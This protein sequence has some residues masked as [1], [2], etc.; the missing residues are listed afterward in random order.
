MSA[1]PG[2]SSNP[3]EILGLDRT[4]SF[5]DV[6]L[7]YRR[8]ARQ[9]HPDANPD[10][11]Q[12]LARFTALRRAYDRLKIFYQT[13]DAA[14]PADRPPTPTGGL[15]VQTASPATSQ[16]HLRPTPRDTQVAARSASGTLPSDG[17]RIV[18]NI[19][20]HVPEPS[21]PGTGSRRAFRRTG[22]MRSSAE[23]TPRTQADGDR[24]SPQAHPHGAASRAAPLQFGGGNLA[25]RA[26]LICGQPSVVAGDDTQMFYALVGVR[27]SE[28]IVFPRLP[29]NLCLVLD[30]SSSM[31]RGGKVERL[32]DTVRGI[33]DQLDEED[34]LSI[35]TFGDRAE[36]LLPA[37]PLRN[38]AMVQGAIDAMRCRGGT[39]ISRGLTVGLAEL[40]RNASRALSHMILL[41]DGQTY[42][43][44]MIC[45]DRAEEAADMKV[46]VTAYGLGS[47][48]NSALL[49]GIAGATG[50]HSDYI[51]SP[52]GMAAA[53]SAR[54]LALQSTTLCNVSLTAQV[55]S[56][57]TIHRATLVTPVMRPLDF[58]SEQG[59]GVVSLGDISSTTDYR[60]LFEF[61]IG[62][63]KPG[64]VSIASLTLCYDVPGLQRE[65]EKF[66]VP[67]TSLASADHDPSR[68]VDSRITNALRHTTVNR[69]QQQAWSEI[70]SGNLIKGTGYLKRAAEHLE[71]AGHM[72]L[73][74]VAAT[75]AA[76]VE[77]GNTASDENIKRIIYGTRK[78]G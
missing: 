46:G 68:P 60:L 48:W 66:S 76:R 75:E 37:Q 55:A 51:E 77:A 18:P 11:P 50:G 44:E 21:V 25:A 9:Y 30:H 8:L 14:G 27:A 41:T 56:N 45:L 54:V 42:G 2:M 23:L 40:S 5:D 57:S 12:A 32:K 29:L 16:S 62:P 73:A 43:D 34:F 39:E 36:V 59:S 61:V 63:R 24:A 19:R 15:H 7:A 69:L 20:E 74:Q 31:L 72:E 58:G 13:L 38:K 67:I 1:P 78:L 28:G 4:A 6:K 70:R 3:F 47:D 53:F 49:D 35:V 22:P 10:D 52:D 33:I 71:V 17:H 65:A 64:P 26:E